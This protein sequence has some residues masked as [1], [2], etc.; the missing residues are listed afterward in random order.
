MKQWLFIVAAVVFMGCEKTI[1][2]QPD[3]QTPKLV[4][5]AQ[6]ENGQQPVVILTTS[7]NYFSNITPELITGSFVRNAVIT[8]SDGTKTV[9]LK[10]YDVP[11]GTYH[12]YYYSTEATGLMV[13]EQG[14]RYDMQITADGQQYSTF[15]TIP[16][17]TKMIDSLWW[18]Q[19]PNN[20]DSSKV[21]L[22]SRVTDPPGYGNYIRYFTKVNA[23]G[24]YLP[25]ANSVFDDQVIDGKTYDIQV[26]QG[27]DRNHPPDNDEYGYFHHGDT[28]TVKF[29]N[30]DKATYT[31]WNT[32]EFAYDGIG[33]PF[34]SPNKVLG[35]ISNN[36]LG[37]FS[38][39]SA[40]YKQ[41]I[42]PK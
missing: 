33:N 3:N 28:I 19:A 20:D 27:I 23:A 1:Q 24:A 11:V 29:C 30:I 37:A 42:I 16:M 2:F 34:S 6:I 40:Q 9:T 18:K 10:E 7:L 21:V 5:D 4:V 31:F 25:G 38:G 22:M 32:W 39:Y 12:V 17:L 15:T 36:A 8:L 35:N 13:G 41:L 26:D 14:K